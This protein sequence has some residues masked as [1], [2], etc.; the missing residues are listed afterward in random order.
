MRGA[1]DPQS[2]TFPQRSHIADDDYFITSKIFG[3]FIRCPVWYSIA[4]MK[5]G[6]LDRARLTTRSYPPS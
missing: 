2:V 5:T 6:N 1:N 4:E 3:N